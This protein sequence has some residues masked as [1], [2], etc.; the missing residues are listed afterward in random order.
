MFDTKPPNLKEVRQTRNRTYTSSKEQYPTK[1][2]LFLW[3]V[4]AKFS[5]T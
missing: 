4:F 1:L 5:D 2:L 3:Y